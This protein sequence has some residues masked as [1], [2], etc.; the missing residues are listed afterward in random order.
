MQRWLR[1]IALLA[2]LAQL[3]AMVIYSINLFTHFDLGI[4]FAILNQATSLIA[5]GHLNPYNT[6]YPHPFW[7][8]QF[9]L[10]AWPLAL[11][12]VVFP[13]SLS[14]LVVQDLAIASASFL[15]IG[16]SIRVAERSFAHPA[17]KLLVVGSVALLAVANPYAWQAA[18]FDV[19][20][21]PLAA[22]GLLLGLTGFWEKRKVL[23]WAG[24]A[25][26]LL[27]GTEAA[28]LVT[29]LGVG[30]FALRRMRRRGA[31]VMVLGIAWLGLAMA[32][33]A[34][35][36][37]P[38]APSY[39]YL[40]HSSNQSL[41]GI[42]TGMI[43]HPATPLATF[44][45]R[46]GWIARIFIY[47]GLLG[48][49]FLPALGASVAAIGANALQSS[50]SFITLQ[51]G[52]QNYPETILLLAGFP[53]VT[54]WLVS[55]IA[56]RAPR[57]APAAV[58]AAA[59]ALSL[60]I[61]AGALLYDAGIPPTWL[62]IPPRAATVLDG[63]HLAPSTQVFA[64]M[65]IIGRFADRK[66]V[67]PWLATAQAIPVC[68]STLEIIVSAGYGPKYSM[69][70]EVMPFV[71]NLAR[72]PEARLVTEGTNIFVYEVTGLKKNQVLVAPEATI[73]MATPSDPRCAP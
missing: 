43:T 20:L 25:I 1:L 72:L 65:P 5:S 26:A 8:D 60:A 40:A 73:R 69:V 55:A 35:Q 61:G 38:L 27:S 9:N 48:T 12:R 17:A 63:V 16:F 3:A 42:F 53:I 70:S 50:P 57:L 59:A 56:K 2:A 51:A 54:A 24:L 10:L 23:P 32:L 21:Q 19:H 58:P 36:S 15:V 7:S 44:M 18:S 68:S 66:D 39:G 6:L 41:I 37:T 67:I 4:D 62:I 14:L 31:V 29:G 22:V 52:F 49:L 71:K 33:N 45:G 13:S 46:G 34:H 28:L 11:V 30:M 47:S 64:T